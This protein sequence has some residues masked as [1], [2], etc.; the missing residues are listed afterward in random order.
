MKIGSLIFLALTAFYAV[1]TPVYWILSRDLTGTTA[2]ILTFFLT[3][4]IS[5]YLCLVAR[6]LD[7]A[8]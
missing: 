3:L 7:P 1:I 2:L 4:M 8:P 5:G 6:R